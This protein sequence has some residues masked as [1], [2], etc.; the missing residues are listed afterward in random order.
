VFSCAALTFQRR[1][2]FSV[3]THRALATRKSVRLALKPW[4]VPRGLAEDN[5]IPRPTPRTKPDCRPTVKE[6]DPPQTLRGP[7]FRQGLPQVALEILRGSARHRL[8]QVRTPVFLIGAAADCDLVLGDPLFPAVHTY[9][10]VRNDGV[11]LRYL[12]EGPDLCVNGRRIESTPVGHGD[13][14]Q[15]GS[16]EFRLHVPGFTGNDDDERRNYDRSDELDEDLHWDPEWAQTQ[17][18]LCD[19]PSPLRPRQAVAADAGRFPRRASA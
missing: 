11:S 9:L 2:I 6:L 3:A 15:M 1:S 19:L 4:T 13:L 17:L 8:R 10:Y 5:S 12:G 7:H 18:L 14:L 16:Y